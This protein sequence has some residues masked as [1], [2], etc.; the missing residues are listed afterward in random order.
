MHEIIAQ[1]HARLLTYNIRVTKIDLQH[2]PYGY[3]SIYV[4]TELL[5]EES[6]SEQNKARIFAIA[7]SAVSYFTRDNALQRLV[8]E[9]EIVDDKVAVAP[10]GFDRETLLDW[11]LGKL[12]DST[13]LKRRISYWHSEIDTESQKRSETTRGF[14]ACFHH[15]AVVGLHRQGE[16]YLPGGVVK[17]SGTPTQIV[18][19]SLFQSMKWYLEQ[20]TGLELMGISRGFDVTILNVEQK[21]ELTILYYGVVRGALIAGTLLSLNALPTFA[22]VCGNPEAFIQWSYLQLH[23]GKSKP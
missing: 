7:N 11:H 5:S 23:Q 8:V 2:D 14:I 12:D 3:L 21:P 15:D 1:L 13:L 9:T 10:V 17:G 22:P 20:E 16:W 18:H 19:S 4:H 6:Y